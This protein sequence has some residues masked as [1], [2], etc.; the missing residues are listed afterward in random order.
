MRF[1]ADESEKQRA[2]NLLEVDSK[3]IEIPGRSEKRNAP[4]GLMRLYLRKFFRVL[5]G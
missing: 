5:P 1:C 4:A 3:E 2:S